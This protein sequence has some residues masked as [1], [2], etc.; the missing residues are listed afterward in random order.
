[1]LQ[2]SLDRGQ[3]GK[4][5]RLAGAALGLLLLAQAAGAAPDYALFDEVLLYNVRNGYVDYDGV[6]AHPK[7]SRFIAQLGEPGTLPASREETLALYINA[8]NAFA[9]QG[10]LD[11]YSPAGRLGRYRYFKRQKYQLLGESITLD[12]L[13]H[14]RLRPLGD[15]RVHFAIVC[16]SISCPRLASGAYLP[17][18]LDRQLDEAARRFVNDNTRNRFDVAQKTAFL[19]QIFDWF[20]DDFA[21]SAGAVPKFIARHV[22]D[23]AVEAALLDGRLAIRYLPYDW[24]LNGRYVAA[25]PD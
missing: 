14:Q 18:R 24:D 6:R 21:K 1:M 8:Y 3:K 17:E 22:D 4:C 12:T 16:A 13:E 10:I 20:E 25:A 9:I 19:S 15:A 11:G 2:A 7:F 23:A 5:C